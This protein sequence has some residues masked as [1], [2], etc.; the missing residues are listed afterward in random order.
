LVS[1]EALAP[2]RVPS[3]VQ[4]PPVAD[5]LATDQPWGFDLDLEVW[6]ETAE[7]RA[8]GQPSVC[9]SRVPF[10]DMYWTPAQQLAHMTVNGASASTGDLFASG[11]VSGPT[12][13]SAGSLIE[14]SW[15]G[16]RPI[17]LPD[18]STRTFLLDGDRVTLT[19]WAGDEPGDRI[20]LGSI[21]GTIIANPT[22]VDPSHGG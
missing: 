10:G 12:P 5:Y 19:G 13:D 4:D 3:P 14:L 6:L 1:I 7:M 16:E 22:Q 17:E 18:G 9:L 2:F 8:A 20:G 15:N 21:S 11:T